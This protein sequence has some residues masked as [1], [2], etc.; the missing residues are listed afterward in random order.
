MLGYYAELNICDEEGRHEFP[1][2]KIPLNASDKEGEKIAMELAREWFTSIVII[3][4]AAAKFE[5]ENGK[6][7]GL[8]KRRIIS[9][10]VMQDHY[11]GAIA[12]WQK[13]FA[14]IN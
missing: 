11:D 2:R 4:D 7:L 12:I 6:S 13:S 8:P 1:R 10:S 5:K 3:E 14:H 9:T